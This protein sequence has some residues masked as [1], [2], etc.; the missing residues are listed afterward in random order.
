MVTAY[1]QCGS[2]VWAVTIPQT[3][4]SK[5]LKRYGGVAFIIRRRKRK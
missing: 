3:C 5:E 4:S 1:S 2:M